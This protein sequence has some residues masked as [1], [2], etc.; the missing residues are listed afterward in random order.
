VRIVGCDDVTTSRRAREPCPCSYL[1]QCDVAQRNDRGRRYSG[2]SKPEWSI[3][4]SGFEPAVA[5]F[6]SCGEVDEGDI[7]ASV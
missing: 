3:E 4:G 1:S 6:F 5:R 7:R 2:V